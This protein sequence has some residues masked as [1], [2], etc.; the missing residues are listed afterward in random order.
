MLAAQSGHLSIVL[1][2]LRA[3]ARANEQNKVQGCTVLIYGLAACVRAVY[4]RD[5]DSVR[6]R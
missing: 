6:D 4:V 3:G 2:L 5:V 1:A